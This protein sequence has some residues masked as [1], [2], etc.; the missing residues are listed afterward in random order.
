MTFLIVYDFT[1]I[2]KHISRIVYI[3]SSKVTFTVLFAIK[4]TGQALDQFFIMSRSLVVDE[5]CCMTSSSIIANTEVS[6]ANILIL[7]KMPPVMSLI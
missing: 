3:F 1:I 4:T 7:F 5:V 2:S 6:S